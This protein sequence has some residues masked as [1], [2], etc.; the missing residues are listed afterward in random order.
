MRHPLRTVTHD[1]SH[2]AAPQKNRPQILSRSLLTGE[3]RAK[4]IGPLP[5]V[6][7]GAIPSPC[8]LACSPEP[9]VALGRC[10]REPRPGFLD[11]VA[12]Y[13]TPKKHFGGRTASDFR[14]AVA[15]IASPVVD[16][17]QRSVATVCE[18]RPTNRNLKSPPGCT[19]GLLYATLMQHGESGWAAAQYSGA[20]ELGLREDKK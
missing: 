16:A 1:Q 5:H 20:T 13:L 11:N 8:D 3:T 15:P 18:T 4:G 19:G 2:N 12:C 6:Q 9:T 14:T 10:R 17:V 7:R